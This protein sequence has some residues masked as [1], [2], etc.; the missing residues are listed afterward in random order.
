MRK[1][2]LNV[3]LRADF[4]RGILGGAKDQC[5]PVPGDGPGSSLRW[6]TVPC[7]KDYNAARYGCVHLHGNR[8]KTRF[9]KKGDT[10]AGQ[11]FVLS[12]R[13]IGLKLL[14]K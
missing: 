13:V 7:F 10:N 4:E 11:R 14:L 9:F 12:R 6:N 5:S 2:V 1:K 8:V 3:F